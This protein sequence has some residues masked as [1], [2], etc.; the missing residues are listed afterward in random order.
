M[1]EMT[2]KER[3]SEP[4]IT[5][6]VFKTG[7]KVIL[8]SSIGPAI[9][10]I[11]YLAVILPRELIHPIFNPGYLAYGDAIMF[12]AL[13]WSIAIFSFTIPAMV[14]KRVLFTEH[15]QKRYIMPLMTIVITA[16][17]LV[18]ATWISLMRGV[19]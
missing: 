3:I 14:H 15:K 5:K 17:F 9:Y 11:I 18:I 12:L 16:I 6:E 4:N 1:V 13:S 19:G 10:T 8:Y 7:R 2:F